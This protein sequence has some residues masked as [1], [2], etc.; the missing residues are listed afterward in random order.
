[1]PTILSSDMRHG[2]TFRINTTG[3]EAVRSFLIQLESSIPANQ[4]LFAAAT[5][6][7]LPIIG[8]IHPA[9]GD[10]AVS[11][12]TPS[13]YDESTFE[14]LVLVDY[15]VRS[16]DNTPAGTTAFAWVTCSSTVEN[17]DQF[18]DK[19]GNQLLVYSQE[20][21][22]NFANFIGQP[23]SASVTVCNAMVTMTRREPAPMDL[24]K[25]LT[26]TGSVNSISWLGGAPRTWKC[27]GMDPK[28]DGK[29]IHW[30]YKFQYNRNT[31]DVVC[32][33]KDPV[34]QQ[35]VVNQ[36]GTSLVEGNGYAVF[37]VYTEQ[38]FNRIP[39]P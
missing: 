22:D 11:S 3:E 15:K 33:F 18:V 12:I 14:Y 37:R 34:T 23:C 25:I 30:T 17:Q 27:I 36:D 8:D 13:C 32:F 10:L 20:V 4:R 35:I 28:W 29:L 1:M 16:F 7:G 39:L 9:D 31:W 38:D 5:C 6:P 26:Y 2:S 21:T 24:G 19:D